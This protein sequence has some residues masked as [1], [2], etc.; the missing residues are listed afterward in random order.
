MQEAQLMQLSTHATR[1][2]QGSFKVI[3]NGAIGQI[4]YD[5]LFTFNNN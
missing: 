2:R 1:R 4:I 5:F 3:G